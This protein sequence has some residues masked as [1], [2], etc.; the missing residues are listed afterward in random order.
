MFR[1]SRFQRAFTKQ[2][3]H[4]S[5]YLTKIK[6]WILIRPMLFMNFRAL[7]GCGHSYIGKTERFLETRLSEHAN[8]NSYKTSAITQHLINCPDTLYLYVN[9]NTFPDLDSSEEF[10]DKMHSKILYSC[11]YNNPNQLLILEALLIKRKLPE[12]N[13]GLKA[14]NNYL[15]F[16][17]AT[18]TH[19]FLASM[20][21]T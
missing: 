1:K 2:K 16:C 20:F 21:F 3:K 13:C 8:I 12:L 15:Y 9:L 17:N 6:F 14:S 5:F 10:S 19:A 11:K 18:S 7:A 4:L